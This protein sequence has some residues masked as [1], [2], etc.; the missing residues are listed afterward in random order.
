MLSSPS[1]APTGVCRWER[2]YKAATTG[3]SSGASGGAGSTAV[4][5]EPGT[6]PG[7]H[8]PVVASFTARI[9]GRSAVISSR[10]DTAVVP[11]GVITRVA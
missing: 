11:Q 5:S 10:P 6:G 8:A 3:C 2:G 7:T 9:G 4:V 1:E